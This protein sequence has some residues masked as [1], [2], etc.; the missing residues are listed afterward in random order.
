MMFRTIGIKRTAEM[1][2]IKMNP[3]GLKLLEA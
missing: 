2:E 3:N 1:I